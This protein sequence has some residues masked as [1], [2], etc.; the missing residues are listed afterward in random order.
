VHDCATFARGWVALMRPELDFAVSDAVP[1][2]DDRSAAAVTRER[3]LI[4]RVDD[5][6]A[7]ERRAP[8][9]AQRGD[10]LVMDVDGRELLAI[11]AGTVAVAPGEHG[12]ATVPDPHLARAAWKV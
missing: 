3:S 5:W 9:F 4:E 1:R 6:G 12:I 7:L 11:H 10:L 8:A 2:T